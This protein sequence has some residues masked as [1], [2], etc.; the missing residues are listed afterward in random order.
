MTWTPDQLTGS[1]VA[2]VLHWRVAPGRFLTSERG[3]LPR[4]KFQPAQKI[5]DA[6]RLVEAAGTEEYSLTSN[7]DGN[8]CATVRING[9]TSEGCANTKPLAICLALAAAVGIEVDQ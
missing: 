1:L 4:W 9:T 5:T 6:I 7:A 3:W 2:A 8:F